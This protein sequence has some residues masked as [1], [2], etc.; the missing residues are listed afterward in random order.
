MW[1]SDKLVKFGI[2]GAAAADAA[3]DTDGDVPLVLRTFFQESVAGSYRF[4]VFSV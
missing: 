4:D 2:V 3:D 1:C